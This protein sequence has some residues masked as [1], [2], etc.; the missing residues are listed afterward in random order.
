MLLKGHQNKQA[1]K[2]QKLEN[3]LKTNLCEIILLEWVVL[4]VGNNGNN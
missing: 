3:I 2:C 4:D 1:L